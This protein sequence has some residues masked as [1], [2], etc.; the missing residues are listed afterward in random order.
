MAI[1]RQLV[2]L[3]RGWARP[4]DMTNAD[5][6]VTS[7]A[8][9]PLPLFYAGQESNAERP[10]AFP[11][12]RGVSARGYHDDLWVM[13]MYSGYASPK[14]TNARFKKLLNAGQTGL[15]IALD[16]PTQI[17][18][19]SD[20]PEAISE[21]GKVG[22]PLNSVEDMLTLLDGLP[23]EN[24]RQMRSSANAIGPIFA[25]FVLVALEEMGVDPR[26]FRL[27]LQNDPLKEFSAR[28]T[29]IFPPEAS[30]RF[31][32]DVIE[33]FADQ[34]PNWEP[35]QFCGY[36][37]RDAGG[38]VI[39]EVA[40]SAANGIAYLDEA[41]RRGVDIAKVAP[42][43][44][45]FLSSGVDVFEEAAKFRAARRLWAKL[46]TERYRVPPERAGLRIFAYTLGG[47][48]TAQEPENN[49]V[50]IAYE[51]LA[52]VL[53]GVQTLATSSWDEAHSLP[54]AQAAHLALRTQQ[55]LGYEAGVAKVVDPLGGSFYIEDL[56]ARL[57]AKIV[58]YVARIVERGGAIE[59]ISSRFIGEELAEA[60]YAY[61]KEI[62]SG[63][64]PLVGVN[65]KPHPVS[66]PA[67]AAFTL[68]PAISG[69]A[70]E[71]LNA[72]RAKRD[73]GRVRAA[74]ADVERAARERRNTIPALIEAT[75]ARASLGEMTEV[76]ARVFGR[77]SSGIEFGEVLP[78]KSA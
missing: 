37:I 19:D 73:A 9:L 57:E 26:S 15:S 29:W 47:A 75:R 27:F 12:S 40:V 65:F 51:A 24:I 28:G 67:G 18:L 44:F 31:A 61:Q 69:E 38:T 7:S 46:L 55:I 77:Y 6:L 1:D 48:L 13:G 62:L 2:E 56:T 5:G 10:G 63:A 34:H 70:I 33:Y 54:S 53:G 17:G 8:R 35:I 58:D 68:P 11:F 23:I 16:L 49:I 52:A 74:L 64:R 3:L 36:H 78:R 43:L 20:H 59:C 14:E 45:L 22:V 76:L 72:I 39:Q 60:A 25:A 21:V 32:V 50:R 66:E 41:V 30:V 4:D 71:A 42:S